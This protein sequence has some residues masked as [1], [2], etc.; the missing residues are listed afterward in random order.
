MRFAPS[1]ALVVL[2][3]CAAP[4]TGEPWIAELAGD[5]PGVGRQRVLLFL[6]VTR[7]A[8]G[9]SIEGGSRRGALS[10]VSGSALAGIY[11]RLQPRGGSL[12]EVAGGGPSDAR[13]TLAMDTPTGPIVCAGAWVDEGISGR[14]TGAGLGCTSGS[15][16]LARRGPGQ[17]RET[18][19]EDYPTLFD[20]FFAAVEEAFVFPERLADE[21]FRAERDAARE[22][23]AGV[24]DDFEFVGLVARLCAPVAPSLVCLRA[25]ERPDDATV[26]LAWAGDVALVRC[27]PMRAGVEEI[28]AAFQAAA[29]ARALVLDLRGAVGY[30]LTPGRI[31]AYLAPRAEPLGYMLGRGRA[32]SGPLSDEERDRL[33]VLT[34]VYSY[35]LYRQ[36]LA[37][38]GAVGG[39]VAPLEEGAFA[40]PVAVL[41]DG[42]TRAGFE[43]VADHL[44]RS[45]R[46]TLV[47]APT[48]GASVDADVI[49]LKNAAG[50]RTGWTAI[51]PAATWV[52]WDGRWME[53]TPV[54]P[55][56]A[57]PPDE[58]LAA[59]LALLGTP[60]AAGIPADSL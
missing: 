17:G 43:P 13:V 45:G 26:E 57:V 10:A 1:V 51:V 37:L 2:A 27:G 5:D 25:A 28:D 34:G 15:F 46:V 23:A 33:T 24:V 14:W 32:D 4:R 29:G 52:S 36:G 19:L 21:D 48:A 8:D 56:V 59:A 7:D 12:V 60:A 42:N 41:I 20:A 49:P 40:G 35:A 9:L 53:R 39:A 11:E 47:G 55:D 18:P 58:A 6:D 3:A 22:R 30:D 50:G 16:T 38:T 31:F 44:R 54:E